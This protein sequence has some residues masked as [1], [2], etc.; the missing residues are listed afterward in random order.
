MSR[1]KSQST[2]VFANAEVTPGVDFASKIFR[3]EPNIMIAIL[4]VTASDGVSETL[5]VT[6]EEWDEASGGFFEFGAFTQATGVTNERIL[7]NE[8]LLT[9]F[10]E[11]IRAVYTFGGT[12]PEFTFSLSVHGK[13]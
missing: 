11:L 9:P 6:F 5:D 10:G 4:D 2:I 8:D 13:A 1:D 12:I 3:F 7:V